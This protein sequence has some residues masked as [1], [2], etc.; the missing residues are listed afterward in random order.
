MGIFAYMKKEGIGSIVF[1]QRSKP[2]KKLAKDKSYKFLLK[3]MK[4]LKHERVLFCYDKKS[5]GRFIIAIHSTKR[6]P[7]LG[8]SRF[9]NYKKEE[10]A[11]FDVLRLSRGMTHK[12]AGVSL[13][14]GGGK[15]CC[16]GTLSNTHLPTRPWR[17]PP[18]NCRR[19]LAG[20]LLVNYPNR[21]YA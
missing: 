17:T 12:A 6:G 4:E 11:I 7:A 3:M 5:K 15:A 10:D 9:F 20:V 16:P 13:R 14:L 18:G 1:T 2:I 21:H 19:D 8:G